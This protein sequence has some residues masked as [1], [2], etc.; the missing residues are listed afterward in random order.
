M[1]DFIIYNNGGL[2]KDLNNHGLGYTA[3]LLNISGKKV[4]VIGTYFL[5]LISYNYIFI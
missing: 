4:L 3:L 5:S 1:I 2:V